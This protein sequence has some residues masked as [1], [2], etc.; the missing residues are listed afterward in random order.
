MWTRRHSWGR[1]S[2]N[3]CAV[4]GGVEGH[5]EGAWEDVHSLP[6]DPGGHGWHPGGRTVGAL[7]A[8][9]VCLSERP[10][11]TGLF[12]HQL[13]GHVTCLWHQ[14]GQVGLSE[15]DGDAGQ[16]PGLGRPQRSQASGEQIGRERA[17]GWPH[18]WVQ[19]LPCSARPIPYCHGALP[20]L[21][22]AAL[23]SLVCPLSLHLPRAIPTMACRLASVPAELSVW[24]GALCKA[25][26]AEC[27]G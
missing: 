13:G 12:F 18:P 20:G 15:G 26:Q 23:L 6:T 7:P 24:L 17:E 4:G 8:R 1:G 22:L 25:L 14:T 3:T 10:Q 21:G 9:G 2:G 27:V 11:E 19:A 16:D 5:C